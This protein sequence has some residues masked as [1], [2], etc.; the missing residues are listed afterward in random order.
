M[1]LLDNLTTIIIAIIGIFATG[2][3]I[4]VLIKKKKSANNTKSSIG[5]KNS[6]IG[7]DV[8]GRDINKRS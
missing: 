2:F 6:K 3:V 7:G 1:E 5:I 8:A 4:K